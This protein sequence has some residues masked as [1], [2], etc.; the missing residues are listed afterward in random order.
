MTAVYV[1]FEVPK[2]MQNKVYEAVEKARDTGKIRKGVNETT[3][4]IERGTAKLVVIAGDVEPPEIV[5]HLPLLSEEKKVDYIY[6][7]SK[8][9]LGMACGLPVATSAMAI[10]E[11]GDAKELIKEIN[12]FL[13]SVRKQGEKSGE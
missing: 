8:K 3:K 10:V 6:V 4:A 1:K 5:A 7:D 13:S 11:A 2:E 12:K 9:E